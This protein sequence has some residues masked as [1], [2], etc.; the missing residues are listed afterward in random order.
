[1]STCERCEKHKPSICLECAGEDAVEVERLED[2]VEQLRSTLSK[3]CADERNLAI[4]EGPVG[5]ACQAALDM[6]DEVDAIKEEMRKTLRAGDRR[7]KADVRPYIYGT[8]YADHLHRI[9]KSWEI[10]DLRRERLEKM[11]GEG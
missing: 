7:Y 11:I 4:E 9:K 1:M 5:H 6:R 3:S 10:Y 8:S 2:K